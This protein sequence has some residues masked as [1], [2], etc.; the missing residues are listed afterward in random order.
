MYP[1]PCG[2]CGSDMLSPMWVQKGKWIQ[3]SSCENESKRVVS[4]SGLEAIEQWN[5]EQEEHQNEQADNQ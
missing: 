1:K 5:K 4:D 2:I 3:C